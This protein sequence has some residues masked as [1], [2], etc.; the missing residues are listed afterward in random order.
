MKSLLMKILKMLG[1]VAMKELL[2]LLLAKLKQ[3]LKIKTGME[4]PNVGGNKG[5]VEVMYC[6]NCHSFNCKKTVYKMWTESICHG[7]GHFCLINN[8]SPNIT[9]GFYDLDECDD[10][11]HYKVKSREVIY[12]K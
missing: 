2:F 7:C 1:P 5:F 10:N 3:L 12:G 4:I 8:G 9:Y 6:L 11:G